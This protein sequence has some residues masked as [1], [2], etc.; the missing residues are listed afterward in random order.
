MVLLLKNLSR[1]HAIIY[2]WVKLKIFKVNAPLFAEWNLTFRCPYQCLYCGANE[3]KIKELETNEILERLSILYKTGIRWITFGGGEPLVKK[4]IMKILGYAKSLGF[5]VYLSSTGS[6]I[7][8][9]DGIEHVVDHIN[10]S[11]DGPADVHDAIR[12][13]GTYER[14][15]HVVNFCK[16]KNISM[17]FLCVISKINI[18]AID[19]VLE[20]AKEMNVKVMFQPAT[21]HL[22]SSLNINPIA[23]KRE[24]YTQVIKKVIDAKRKGYPVRNSYAGLKYL[25]YWPEPHSIWCPAG[26]L[27]FTIE[28]DGS[29]LSCHLYETRRLYGKESN[30]LSKNNDHS[31]DKLLKNLKVPQGCATCWCAPIVELALIWQLNPSAIWNALWM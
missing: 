19:F 8:K 3:L 14:L 12:G 4:D 6:G 29:L 22:D 16:S 2:S 23:P 30:N 9:Y 11:F 24:D 21:L 15:F 17:S 26:R 10:L 25:S 7:E 31:F 18:G 28:P 27:T 1:I 5:S 13:K 20:R